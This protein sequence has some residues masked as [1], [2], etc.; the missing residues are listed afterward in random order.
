MQLRRPLGGS[1]SSTSDKAISLEQ[2]VTLAIVELG[3]EPLRDDWER[4]ISEA[5]D[6]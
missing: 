5:V 1:E 4:L 2:I 3:A 6:R